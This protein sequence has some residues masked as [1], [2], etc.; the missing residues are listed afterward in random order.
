M[1]KVRVYELAK[2][3]NMTNRALLNK[4]KELKI[5]VKSHMSSLEDGDISVIK[6]S[7]FGKKKKNGVKIKPSVIRRRKQKVEE[8]AEPASEPDSKKGIAEEIPAEEVIVKE[9]I[10]ETEISQTDPVKADPEDQPVEKSAEEE[11][12]AKEV[13]LKKKKIRSRKIRSRK[14]RSRKIRSRKIRSR[15]I[16]LKKL[17]Q[18][19]HWKIKKMPGKFQNLNLIHKE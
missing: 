12:K 5:E 14:I 6:K 7:L 2:D 3:L 17:Q 9:V 13:V 11:R 19:N 18:K 10:V 4:M 1:A 15:K 8:I 16:R